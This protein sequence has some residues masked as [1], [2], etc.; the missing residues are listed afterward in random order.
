MW[1]ANLTFCGVRDFV[2]VALLRRVGP[3][4]RSNHDV[5]SFVV[6]SRPADLKT[7]RLW[8]C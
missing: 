7:G 1:D 6:A 2:A 3:A 8:G 5:L 4:S